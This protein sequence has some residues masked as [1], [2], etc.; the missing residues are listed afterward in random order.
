MSDDESQ[1]SNLYLMRQHVFNRVLQESGA[2]TEDVLIR[3]KT[4]R[5]KNDDESLIMEMIASAGSP[6][7]SSK[8]VPESLEA[9]KLDI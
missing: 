5:K 4:P 6:R 9:S 1:E 8:K 2:T 7:D 3:P